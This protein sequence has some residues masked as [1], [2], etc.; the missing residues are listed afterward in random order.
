MA[1][2]DRVLLRR[3]GGPRCPLWMDS[4]ALSVF[5]LRDQVPPS[6]VSLD[7]W[8]FAVGIITL[9]GVGGPHEFIQG[10]FWKQSKNE[11]FPD[12]SLVGF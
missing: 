2:G 4:V 11:T 9:K 12:L 7:P 3:R 10:P 6:L 5:A 8:M 1:Q